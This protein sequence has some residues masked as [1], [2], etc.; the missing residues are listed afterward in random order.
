M[1]TG[2]KVLTGKGLAEQGVYLS[3]TLK[4]VVNEEMLGKLMIPLVSQG[5]SHDN[6]FDNQW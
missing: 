3:Q 6:Q 4:T 1:G 5:L 2:A